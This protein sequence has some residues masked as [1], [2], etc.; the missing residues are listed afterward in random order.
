M[1]CAGN[2]A[3]GEA[4]KG[5]CDK[6]GAGKARKSQGGGESFLIA[7]LKT[8]AGPCPPGSYLMKGRSS[9]R[10]AFTYQ[11]AWTT[12]RALRFFRSLQKRRSSSSPTFVPENQVELICPFA[13]AVSRFLWQ[14]ELV[15]CSLSSAHHV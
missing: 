5:K 9:A 15:P 3:P 2:R 8:G 13:S 1:C 6:Y 4:Y 14:S 10:N 7:I 12:T 11:V